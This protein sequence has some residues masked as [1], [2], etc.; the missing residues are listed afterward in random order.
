MYKSDGQEL[1]LEY[2]RANRLVYKASNTIQGVDKD[3][4]IMARDFD[5]NQLSK[6][7]FLT[8]PFT[9]KFICIKQS[10]VNDTFEAISP[11]T[12]EFMKYF[13]CLLHLQKSFHDRKNKVKLYPLKSV[14]T[15]AITD[16]LIQSKKYRNIFFEDDAISGKY[17]DIKYPKAY[18][19]D[20]LLIA[21]EELDEEEMN[22][23]K[24]TVQFANFTNLIVK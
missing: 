12:E 19:P 15:F 20:I 7:Q 13:E 9:N 17:S 16:K 8:T 14:S 5:I 22:D 4:F 3:I 11:E 1:N 21:V 2:R 23:A 18:L 10:L 6:I 24:P